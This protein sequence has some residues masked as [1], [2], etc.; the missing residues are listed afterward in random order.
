M[1]EFLH[2]RRPKL[3]KMFQGDNKLHYVKVEILFP[4]NFIH[5][6][7]LSIRIDESIKYSSNF[8]TDEVM[9]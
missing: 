2:I 8:V 6:C 7:G 1:F 3:R 9:F 4:Q 5:F